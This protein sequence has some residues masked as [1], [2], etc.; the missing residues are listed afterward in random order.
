MAAVTG[1]Q[2]HTTALSRSLELPENCLYPNRLKA[3]LRMFSVWGTKEVCGSPCL[4]PAGPSW[5]LRPGM[6]GASSSLLL[7]FLPICDMV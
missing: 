3:V 4:V 5:A 7:S 6:L 2:S 1:P